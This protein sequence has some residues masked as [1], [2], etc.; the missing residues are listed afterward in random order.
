MPRAVHPFLYSLPGKDRTRE[1]P[2]TATRD[3]DASRE[4]VVALLER[5]YRLGEPMLNPPDPEARTRDLEELSP[6][7]VDVSFVRPGSVLVLT[8]RPPLDDRDYGNMKQVEPSNTRPERR[9]F[10]AARRHFPILA[11]P[12]AKLA[13]DHRSRL[14]PGFESRRHI[15]FYQHRGGWYKALNALDGEGFRPPPG[16][17]RTAAF[18]LRVEELWPEGPGLLA[19]FGM[20]S[21]STLVWAYRLRRDL[22][23]LLD[24]EGGPL[25]AMAEMEGAPAPQGA[26]D[27]RFAE[28]WKIELVLRHA[29]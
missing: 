11:R 13:P 7:E 5:G 2:V 22:A 27:L 29:G 28:G 17:W 3:G 8:T 21:V 18:L 12:Y 1:R 15:E 9:V 10:A 16:R 20:D 23:W 14:A 26:T 4:L 25:F 6:R 24:G 19:A